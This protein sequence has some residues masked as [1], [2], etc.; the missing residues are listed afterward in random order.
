MSFEFL[1]DEA[2]FDVNSFRA[3]ECANG[4]LAAD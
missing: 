2:L 4:N 1:L 3:R